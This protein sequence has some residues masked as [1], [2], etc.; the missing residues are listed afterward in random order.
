MA[1]LN[2]TCDGRFERVRDVLAANINA[3][4]ETGAALYVNVEGEVV[5]DLWGGWRDWERTLPWTEDT[6]VNV[7]SATKTVTSLALLMLVDRGELDLYAPV[8]RYWPE[9]AQNGKERV[10]VRHLLSHTA[11][12]P[13]WEQPFRFEDAFDV[14][15]STSRLAAQSPWW[16]PGTR[17]TYHAST[18]GHLNAELVRRVTGTTLRS[19]IASDIAGRLKADFY[20]GLDDAESHRVA[21]I[22]P[23]EQGARVEPNVSAAERVTLSAVEE[24][25]AAKIRAGSF[26]GTLNDPATLFNSL[27]WR[28]TE[29]AGSS[30]HANARGLGAIVSAISL[31]GVSRGTRLLST[32]TADLIFHEQANGVDLFYREPVRWG[33]GYALG[34]ADTYAR[35]P[36]PFVRPSRR[37]CFWYGAGGSCAIMDAE[38][39]ITVTYVMN[40]CRPEKQSLNGAYY[41]AIYECV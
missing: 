36:L 22:C 15:A 31:G 11:G 8:A 16:E 41:K 26:S 5:V 39:R 33:I 29:F 10:E 34:S 40:R 4:E 25:I 28:R 32:E 23:S 3:G 7:F 24:A 18:F 1:D 2:G 6:I 37:T 35:G 17:G 19:F 13:G 12:L 38:R 14:A 20:L 9:F 21:D 30:G 27:Q